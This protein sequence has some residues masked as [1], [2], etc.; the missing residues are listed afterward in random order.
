VSLLVSN[1]AVI[2]DDGTGDA[3]TIDDVPLNEPAY[4]GFGYRGN[5]LGLYPLGKVVDRHK[6][7]LT[8]PSSFGKRAEDIHSPSS[9]R[10]RTDNRRHGSRGYSLDGGKLLALVTGPY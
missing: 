3:E 9:K 5:G 7:I 1:G 6:E 2:K 8:L 4:F 10:Q